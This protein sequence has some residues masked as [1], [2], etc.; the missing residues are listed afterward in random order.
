MLIRI[1]FNE[2]R[3]CIVIIGLGFNGLL[4]IAI[5]NRPDETKKRSG[6]LITQRYVVACSR[7]PFGINTEKVFSCFRFFR[8][9]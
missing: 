9:P 4:F 6:S 7:I 3:Y 5:K 1:D 8:I 2:A